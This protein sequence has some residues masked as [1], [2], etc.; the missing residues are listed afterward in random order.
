MSL[1]LLRDAYQQLMAM[2][3]GGVED[4][5][6]LDTLEGVKGD[7]NAKASNIA[8]LIENI[9]VDMVSMKNYEKRMYARRAKLKE[10]KARL[11]KYLLEN[12]Q[13]CKIESV[14]VEEYGLVVKIKK[15]PP[16][17]NLVDK[18]LIPAKFLVES[19]ETKIPLDP[20]KKAI[21]AGEVVPGAELI[22]DKKTLSIK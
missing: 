19:I 17:V 10:T 8:A 1:Y 7:I 15:C 12:M 6:I 3:D 4:Q 9:S 11:E 20:I 2:V 14:N 5:A 13:A 22:T 18:G 16:S 21:Q